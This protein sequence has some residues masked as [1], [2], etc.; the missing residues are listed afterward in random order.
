MN[1]VSSVGKIHVFVIHHQLNAPSLMF[2]GTEL[3]D[4]TGFG[5]SSELKELTV[6]YGLI[7]EC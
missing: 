2:I 5:L 1:Y 3:S 6:L 7:F 4:D